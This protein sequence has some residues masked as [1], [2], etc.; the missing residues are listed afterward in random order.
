MGGNFSSLDI[1]KNKNPGNDKLT[2]CAIPF[3]AVEQHGPVLPIS[4]DSILAEHLLKALA[5]K[6]S[7]RYNVFIYPGIHYTPC[8]SSAEYPGNSSVDNDVFRSYTHSVLSN[9]LKEETDIIMLFNGHGTIEGHLNEVVYKLME[10]Q[11]MANQEPIK[12]FFVA[13]AYGG[14]SGFGNKI[15]SP[16]GRHA[17]WFEFLVLYKIFGKEYFTEEKMSCLHSIQALSGNQ[18]REDG[19]LGLPIKY[20]SQYGTIGPVLPQQGDY[21]LLSEQLWSFLLEH[22]E[23]EI[24]EKID[25][26]I[27]RWAF[28]D[29]LTVIG[30]F[31]DIL[32]RFN[33]ESE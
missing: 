11:Y 7:H 32:R 1:Y 25:T 23:K 8:S 21:T 20:R 14:R 6:V 4:T 13:N 9:F 3:G 28:K 2:I 15:G 22:M 24:V 26:F 30:D 5:E 16:M 29:N 18:G 19:V 12:Y 33:R 17:D 10:R 31:E 27:A